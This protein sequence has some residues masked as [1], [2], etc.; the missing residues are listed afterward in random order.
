MLC[1]KA[2]SSQKKKI[3]EHLQYHVDHG[4]GVEMN[5]FRPGSEAFF[6]LFRE[7]RELYLQGKYTPSSDEELEL[8]ESNIGEFGMYEGEKVPLDFPEVISDLEEAKYKGREVTLGK[9]GAKRIGG[10][11][12]RVYVRNKKNRQGCKSRIRF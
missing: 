6:A 8:L 10:G 7:A 1:K 12:G 5:V 3:S 2:L 11:R 9:K 4:V